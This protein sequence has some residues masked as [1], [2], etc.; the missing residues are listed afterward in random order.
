MKISAEGEGAEWKLAL[1]LKAPNVLNRAVPRLI[2]D[3]ITK[4]LLIHSAWAKLL[5]QAIVPLR[6]K[7]YQRNNKDF[8]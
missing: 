4:N 8:C 7:I 2:M 1:Y 5:S 3:Q 6:R